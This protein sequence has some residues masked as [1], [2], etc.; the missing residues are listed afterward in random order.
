[1]WFDC[2]WDNSPKETKI[3]QKLTTI[4]HRTPFNNDQ[5]QYRIVSLFKLN[6]LTQNLNKFIIFMPHLEASCFLSVRPFIHPSVYL[7]V[8][9][10]RFRLYFLIRYSSC[11][12]DCFIESNFYLLSICVWWYMC[13]EAVLTNLQKF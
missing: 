10:P 7:S 13:F 8:Y 6:L 3:T 5:I 9:L 11:Y 2:Q 1:M 4:G 12:F